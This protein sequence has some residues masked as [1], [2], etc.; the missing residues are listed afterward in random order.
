[1][2]DTTPT[3]AQR[4]ESFVYDQLGNRKGANTI[5]GRGNITF[6]RRDN[7]LNQYAV[8]SP[9]LNHYDDE[10][11]PNSP[12]QAN[13]NLRQDGW[14]SSDYNALNQPL[15]FWSNLIVPAGYGLSFGF[16]PLGRRVKQWNDAAA[17]YFYYDGWNLIQEGPNASTADRIY[18]HGNRVDEVVA[19]QY[20]G[21]W[22]YHH[23]DARGHCILLT[24][25]S[26]NIVEQ[27]DY[28]AFAKPYFYRTSAA[29]SRRRSMSNI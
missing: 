11:A 2:P 13:G 6:Y 28:D 23:Y 12:G 22:A 15:W 4:T 25:A 7:G 16:D 14:L 21:A 19:D 3:G 1:M 17:T 9:F 26:G 24:D 5:A 20:V 8:S 10:W 27:Y 18:A 29:S